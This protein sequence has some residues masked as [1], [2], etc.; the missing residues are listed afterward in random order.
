MHKGRSGHGEDI[1]VASF[2]DAV[3]L[4]YTWLSLFVENLQVFTRKGDFLTAVA[5]ASPDWIATAE[6]IESRECAIPRFRGHGV[7]HF[8]PRGDILYDED[9]PAAVA[10]EGPIGVA[11]HHVITCDQVPPRFDRSSKSACSVWHVP[12]L[13]AHA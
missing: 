7:A 8:E 12:Q 1:A 9:V 4:R 5:I 13:T 11:L 2:Y 6:P 10:A 3:G